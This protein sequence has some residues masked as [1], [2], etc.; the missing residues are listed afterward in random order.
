MAVL[1]PLASLIAVASGVGLHL[2]YFHRGEHHMYGIRY[3]QAS[4]VTFIAS[5]GILTSIYNVA[6][7]S[8][9]A[10]VSLSTVYILL[11][12]YSSLLCYRLIWHPLR[13]FP[14][15]FAARISSLW[16]SSQNING[17]NHKVALELYKKYG[18]FVRVGS[19]DLMIVHPQGVPAVHSSQSKCRKASWYDEDWPRESVHVTRNHKWHQGRR[20]LWSQAFSDKA[21]RGYES[22]IAAYNKSLIDRLAEFKGQP[23]NAAKWFNYYSFDV[24]GNL[25][26][27]RDFGMLKSGQQHWAVALLDDALGVQSMKLPTWIFRM[28][29]AI[30]GLT[31]KYWKFIEFCDQQLAAKIADEEKYGGSEDDNLMSM[32]I[33]HARQNKS[34]REDLILQS[35]SRT[36]IVAG[37]DTTAATLS[38]VFYQLACHPEHVEILRKE[39]LP[40]MNDDG[41]FDHLKIQNADHLNAV[42]NEALRLNPVPPT[43]IVRKTPPE[44]ID[45]DGTF[46]PG[47]MHVWTPQY[48][49]GRSELA[50]ER[51]YEFIPERW[52]SKPSMIR[53]KEGYAPFLIGP[54]GCI[55]RPL[56]QMQIRTVVALA[57]SRFDIEYPP[58]KD[59]SEFIENIKDRFTWGLA[60]LNICFKPRA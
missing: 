6:F 24:M 29:I 51:P 47:N 49:I 39:L 27:G 52:Y 20:R 59:G 26:F 5:V 38:H 10:I 8:A 40:L 55:G 15:P 19:S 18:P 31:E 7:T 21:L 1:S 2:F 3:L 16:L 22:R 17:Q 33:A 46:I 25:A 58:G 54:Y 36:I 37:S 35:D 34:P 56:A 45:V 28:M 13:G 9:L 53:A 11:G 4:I 48:V 12:L 57:V 14:G 50:Y 44:G 30:P 41:T 42:I 32:L 23:V 43:A 60:D